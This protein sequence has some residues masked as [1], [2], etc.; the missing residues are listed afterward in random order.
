[1]VCTVC[2]GG[3]CV[4]PGAP[5]CTHLVVDDRTTRTIP[6]ELNGRVHVV[7]AEVS[8][9]FLHDQ[10]IIVYSVMYPELCNVI[11]FIILAAS[12]YFVVMYRCIS[13]VQYI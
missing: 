8:H 11:G 13:K 2:E 1:M 7:K 9:T 12:V 10:L 5:T 6:F 3:T 4:E